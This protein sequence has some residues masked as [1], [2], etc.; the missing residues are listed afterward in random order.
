MSNKKE[1]YFSLDV[2]VYPLLMVF[3][4]WLVYWAEIRFG[5]DFNF[6]GVLPRKVEGLKGIVFSPFIHGSLKHL[7]NNSIPLLVLTTAL[8][9][10]YRDIRWK[11][12]IF[13]L[14]ITGISTWVIGRPA[15]H[16]GASGVVYMLA[17]FLFFK[18]IFSKQYQLT[19]LSLVV[20][21]LYGGLIWYVMPGDPTISWEGHLSGFAV[22]FLFAFFFRGNA[23]AEKKYEW[24]KDDYNPEEDVFLQHF[25]D[26][27]NFIEKPKPEPAPEELNDLTSKNFKF[28]YTLKK[29]SDKDP[30]TL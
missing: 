7:F 29:D 27:G 18:G 17:A 28:V 25:D 11:V 4:L 5:W 1:L 3:A 10:F 30:D 12:L 24:E 19:A 15:Y 21:F 13:G 6:L 20:V 9:Y 16:I 14:L 22:G 8:F 23:I 2:I 26:D